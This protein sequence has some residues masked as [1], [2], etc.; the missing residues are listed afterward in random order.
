[1][2]QAV[3]K[4]CGAAALRAVTCRAR[5]AVLC[6]LLC[7]KC[8]N[9]LVTSSLVRNKPA[10]SASVAAWLDKV[11]RTVLVNARKG[12]LLMAHQQVR[13]LRAAPLGDA[14]RLCW[15]GAAAATANACL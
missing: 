8:V 2:R 15:P 7:F 4:H 13:L 9:Y 6:R 3:S 10:S 12:G 5:C 11:V 14:T 1:M